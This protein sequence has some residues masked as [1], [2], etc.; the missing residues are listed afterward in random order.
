VTGERDAKPVNVGAGDDHR[1]VD[2]VVPMSKL[3]SISGRVTAKLDGHVVNTG[4]VT[5]HDDS[6][7]SVLKSQV[8]AVQPD[9]TFRFD[10][11]PS[12]HYTL[13]IRT[14]SLTEATGGSKKLFGIEIPKTKTLRTFGPDEQKV[15]LGDNDVS[16]VVF[17]LPEVP[18]EKPD[19][20][21]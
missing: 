20:G 10:Y 16:G 13:K 1:G 17:S 9:G 7:P 11:V 19:M 4:S 6:E 3:H 21:N 2:L 12:G 18:V 5:M 14:A 15:F 8:A